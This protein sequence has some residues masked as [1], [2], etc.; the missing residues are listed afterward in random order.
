M[1]ECFRGI[2]LPPE[3]LVHSYGKFVS[4]AASAQGHADGD[5]GNEEWQMRVPG[6]GG[7]WAV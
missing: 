4:F 2:N 7:G 1:F 5:H 3:I 6:D